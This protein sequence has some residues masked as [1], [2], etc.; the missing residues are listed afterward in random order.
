MVKGLDPAA[1]SYEGALEAVG[2]RQ[3]TQEG[4]GCEG[5]HKVF[6]QNAKKELSIG[7]NHEKPFTPFTSSSIG[8]G[9]RT[10]PED[11]AGNNRRKSK[12]FTNPSPKA[13]LPEGWEEFEL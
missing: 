8:N 10:S 3:E 5:L 2:D 7:K 13:P 1:K 11:D 12:P 6:P 9:S 4:E